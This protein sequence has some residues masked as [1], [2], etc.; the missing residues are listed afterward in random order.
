[1]AKWKKCTNFSEKISYDFPFFNYLWVLTRFLYQPHGLLTFSSAS[2]NCVIYFLFWRNSKIGFLAILSN[3]KFWRSTS[4]TLLERG[5]LP[6]VL[7]SDIFVLNVMMN[8]RRFTTN[9]FIIIMTLIEHLHF[10]DKACNTGNTC[11]NTTL[12]TSIYMVKKGKTAS[13]PVAN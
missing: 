9:F 4:T 5:Y 3:P 13:G 11:A 12:I 6:T 7:Q 8:V 10:T 1:M 2:L